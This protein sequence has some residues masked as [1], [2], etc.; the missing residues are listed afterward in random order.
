LLISVK[1]IS[2]REGFAAISFRCWP[3]LQKLYGA[4]PC[5]VL[6]SLNQQG[7]PA[8]CEGDPAG[9]L[10]MLLAKFLS[11][12]PSTLMDIVDWDDLKNT[13]SLWHCGPTACSWA[14][15]RGATLMPHN[16]DGKDESGRPAPGLPGIV[17]MEFK[18]GPVTFFRTM[19]AVDDEFAVQG[20]IVEDS[21]RRICGSFGEMKNIQVYGRAV[22]AID[23]RNIILERC[24]PHHYTL[25]R[26]HVFSNV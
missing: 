8:A 22:P 24:L 23:L 6:S 12:E 13:L 19:G 1:E 5:S 20:N 9:A 2:D 7:L 3:E 18:P 15:G 26:G 4:W 11:P 25:A 10:D 17:D 16:V 14:S 21:E